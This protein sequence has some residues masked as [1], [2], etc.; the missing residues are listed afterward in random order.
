VL[1]M[2][3]STC[4]L[5]IGSGDAHG[6]FR[7]TPS[8]PRRQLRLPC[9]TT[10]AASSRSSTLPRPARRSEA[11][12]GEGGTHRCLRNASS[13]DHVGQRSDRPSIRI[14]LFGQRE[15]DRGR[16]SRQTESSQMG[17]VHLGP[18]ERSGG[19]IPATPRAVR[20]SWRRRLHRRTLFLAGCVGSSG[21]AGDECTA[22]ST[23]CSARSTPPRAFMRAGVHRAEP[24]LRCL[25]EPGNAKD[26]RAFGAAR[27]PGKDDAHRRLSVVEEFRPIPHALQ[28]PRAQTQLNVDV[29]APTRVLAATRREI[30]FRWPERI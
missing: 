23:K 28:E 12:S 20:T 3:T 10:A 4:E 19:H 26:R 22:R 14:R 5:N 8:V 9:S 11:R 2:I 30:T 15:S 17:I 13:H 21:N 18:Y 1:I 6:T 24:R 27:A 16:L 29:D 25:V 7:V